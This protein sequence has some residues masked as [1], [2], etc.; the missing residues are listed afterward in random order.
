[1]AYRRRRSYRRRRYPRKSTGGTDYIRMAKMAYSGVRYLKSL[2]NVE[3]HP[4]DVSALVN[5]VSGTG[6]FTLLNGIAQGDSNNQRQGN[7]ILLRSININ[8]LITMHDQAEHTMVRCILFFDKE[9]N[10]AT[11][12]ITDLLAGTGSLQN[13]N[14]NESSRFYVL[15]DFRISLSTTGV[16][17]TTRRIYRR[18]QRHTHYDSSTGNA[19]DIVDYSLWLLCLSD[20]GTN[21]PTVSI[22]SQLLFI[23]N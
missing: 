23:D 13:Y 10:G 6:T 12:L 11:P 1:M 14:H 5:P 3:K 22:N 8:L 9:A 21:T 18:L 2:V 20:E 4:L 15:S 19:S 7:S 17:E 16:K